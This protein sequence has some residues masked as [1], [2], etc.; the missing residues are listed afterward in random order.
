MP[1]LYPDE[2]PVTDLYDSHFAAFPYELSAFQKHAIQ[3]IVDGHHVLVCAPTGSG[4][5]LPAE[6]AIRH[7][8]S[9]GKK[10]VYTSPIKALSNQKFHEF[11]R[12]FPEISIGLCTGD[13]KTNPTA[14]LMIVTA[15]ILNNA[16]VHHIDRTNRSELPFQ[17]D[18][19]TE[20]AAVVMDEVHYI[21]DAARGHVWEQTIMNCPPHVQLVMLS[22]T[23][24]DPAKFAAW[25]ESTSQNQE[26]P[27]RRQVALAQTRHRIVP[28]THY[29]YIPYLESVPKIVKDKS[30]AA[31]LR[32]HTDRLV[33]VQTASNVFQPTAY[34]ET[35]ATLDLYEKHAIRMNP[36]HTLNQLATFMKGKED[37]DV[38]DCL[39][40]A[41]VFV[42]SR[43]QVERYAAEITASLWSFDAKEP[44]TIAHECEQM[45]RKLPNW[46]EYVELPEYQTLVRHLEKGVA[47]HHS[48]MIP[49]L[50]EIVEL[51]IAQKKVRLLFAT[52]SFAIGLDCPI[53]TAVF[54]GISKFD[55]KGDRLFY[56]HEYTQMAGRAG[57][58]GIDTIG[59]VIHLPSMYRMLPGSNEFRDVLK[60]TP[61]KLV[62]KFH[63]D[64]SMVL[65]T[66]MSQSGIQF[67]EK[68][69]IRGEL[70]AE[71]NA[72]QRIAQE[73]KEQYNA[74][75][76][77]L[78]TSL[79][80]PM[81]TCAQYN[82][83]KT[84]IKTSVNKK[85]KE[86]EREF[87][88]LETEWKWVKDDAVRV[89]RCDEL[90]DQWRKEHE[91]ADQLQHWLQNQTT[92]IVQI[93]KDD[94]F[95]ADGSGIRVE[96]KGW[97][98]SQIAEIHPLVVTNCIFL[99]DQMD[100][101]SR[102]QLVGWLSAFCDA[103][104]PEE[105]RAVEPV[106]KDVFLQNR[107]KE[108]QQMYESYGDRE[109]D[110]GLHTGIEYEGVLCFDMVDRM[111]DWCLVETG[112]QAK[113]FIQTQIPVSAGDFVKAVLKIS[114]TAKELRA[115]ALSAGFVQFAAK[116]ELV[117]SM[118]LKY[119]VTTQSLYL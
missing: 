113:Q 92:Q 119:V 3:A 110:F 52:E 118:V 33:C 35:M 96:A 29:T 98:A 30:A 108:M 15:E 58:R 115:V 38:D 72:Q 67:T 28:L 9:I 78:Q 59:N 44:Y 40:P 47:T 117:D 89:A 27:T 116:L 39:L 103:R 66:V 34:K 60:G 97:V 64:Y 84:T 4:K 90:K 82:A 88:K 68:S 26:E 24:D 57:R 74:M 79:R 45:I 54:T 53:R 41:I 99:W 22:A 25:I 46:R 20:L 13:I 61:Q 111:M 93:L 63:V 51:L 14:D 6:F 32:D 17:I 19:E 36:K 42:L 101:F 16:L 5:T 91:A 83:L 11:S 85:R 56:S 10:V 76:A 105:E 86:A 107:L 18:I 49:V 95:L 106:S 75:C 8:T 65:K 37:P 62:S 70:D 81:E 43:K 1:I 7:F 109:R 94:G 12:K 100:R 23:L 55:G 31:R 80:T 87:S 50:R 21:N 102:V 114:A 2:Y 48:G 112:D 71:W 73:A 77:V 69:M 104:L